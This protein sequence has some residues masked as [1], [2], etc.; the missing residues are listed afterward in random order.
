MPD[1]LDRLKA[2]LADHWSLQ[3]SGG[4]RHI[5]RLF[6]WV[7]ACLAIGCVSDQE[8]QEWSTWI[9][10]YHHPIRS[11]TSDDFSDL[12][13]LEPLLRDRRIVQ[14][15][16]NGHGI[17][18]FN[19]VKVR[20]IKYLHEELDYSVVAF[21]SRLFECYQANEL[22]RTLTA[23]ELMRSCVYSV[24]HTEEA[25]PLFQYMLETRATDR[26]LLLAGFD[27]IQGGLN[28][29]DR[30]GFFYALINPV[31]PGYAER[32]ARLDS[33][34]LRR[35]G[36]D[37]REYVVTHERELVAVYDSLA[38]FFSDRHHEIVTAADADPQRVELAGQVARSVVAFVRHGAA[39]VRD[40]ESGVASLIRDSAMADN[41][42]FLADRLYTEM[43]IVVWAHNSHVRHA[44]S[45][46][47]PWPGK[48][49][50]EW[51]V[52]RRRDEVY[53]VGL[54]MYKGQGA[55]NDRR[56]YHVSRMPR[57]S[58]ESILAHANTPWFFVDL[59]GASREPGTDWMFTART[60]MRDGTWKETLVP[61]QQYDGL[62]FIDAV[63]PPRY[64]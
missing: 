52:E 3:G 48:K 26:P 47:E 4:V 20:L 45:A 25:L 43:K 54:F 16:E 39:Y 2:A 61:R 63:T 15:G 6:T 44:G 28:R 37:D 9:R 12:A 22:A 1:T 30:P 34:F 38:A 31:D 29:R 59:L 33:T 51:V 53:T 24:W 35:V 55:R 13:F 62:L 19:Q 50:G 18:E 41:L 58:L 40:H 57:G 8:N 49:M 10:A 27:N 36:S 7:A 64:R 21:E 32:I 42:D 46:V 17:S 60:V 5:A 23:D 14:L 11:L 56:L